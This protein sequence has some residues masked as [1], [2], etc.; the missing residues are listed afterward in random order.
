MHLDLDAFYP[1]VEQLDDPSLAGCPVIVGGL[2]ERGVV[3]SA[4]YEARKAGVHSAMPMALARRRCKHGTF[5]KPRFARYRE[6]SARIFDL[7]REWTPLVEPLSLDEAYLDV[8]RRSRP[9]MEIAGRIKQQVRNSIG[10]TVS[11]GGA[12]NQIL[13]QLAS[14][15]VQPQGLTTTDPAR[16]SPT[17]QLTPARTS[18]AG[19]RARCSPTAGSGS[20]R[21]ACAPVGRAGRLS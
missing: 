9:A 14:D 10:L 13:A 11:A 20:A 19:G 8:S 6:L 18:W 2:G 3:A 5:L 1:S 15:L 7:Y 16:A 17:L 4:S 21:V 12:H